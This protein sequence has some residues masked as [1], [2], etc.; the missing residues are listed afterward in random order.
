MQW[1]GIFKVIKGRKENKNAL[2]TTILYSAK[3]CCKNEGKI[4]AFL[5]KSELRE[6]VIFIL[7]TSY[8]KGS[9]S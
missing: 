2:S 3:Q 1:D 5:D 7:P 8:A 9:L 4:K 6:F